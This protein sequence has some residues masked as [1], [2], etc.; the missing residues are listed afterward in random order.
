M[1]FM[2]EGVVPERE[3]GDNSVER[4][5]T[6]H[7]EVISGLTLL[8]RKSAQF[9]ARRSTH[10]SARE[11]VLAE[12]AEAVAQMQPLLVASKSNAECGFPAC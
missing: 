6:Q 2:E 7:A 10:L 5:W 8:I 1:A 12:F 9:E 3:C 4:A 11:T